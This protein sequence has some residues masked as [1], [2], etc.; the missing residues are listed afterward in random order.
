MPGSDPL[1]LSFR[2]APGGVD[3]A[4]RVAEIAAFPD[5]V[6]T[7]HREGRVVRLE[8]GEAL[9][10]IPEIDPGEGGSL[11]FRVGR[12]AEGRDV[13]TRLRLVETTGDEATLDGLSVP[14]RRVEAWIERCME[15]PAG[16]RLP[17]AWFAGRDLRILG[18]SANEDL[19]GRDGD[20]LVAGG[21]GHDTLRLSGGQDA[22][23]GG[24][25][26]D[27]LVTAGAGAGQRE[28]VSVNL[29]VGFLNIGAR[30]TSLAGLERI[31][32][33]AGDDAMR[34][35]AAAETMLGGRGRDLLIG[36]DGD[37]LLFGGIGADRLT[38]GAGDDALIAGGGRD[39]LRGGAGDDQLWSD[40]SRHAVMDG[41]ADD[42][43]L[44]GGDGRDR[45]RGG[46]GDDVMM[47]GGGDDRGQGGT[48]DDLL[49]GGA[50]DD[51]LRGGEGAD[52]I[53]AGAGDD[54]LLGEAGDDT[55]SGAQGVDSLDG[56]DGADLLA[57]GDGGD[58]LVGGAGDDSLFGGD[59]DDRLH[60]GEGADD[61]VGG[62]GDDR[63][64]GG[65]GDDVLTGDG[66][67]YMPAAPEVDMP[68]RPSEAWTYVTEGGVGDWGGG[69]VIY[70][71][72]GWPTF[73][74]EGGADLF[75]LDGAGTDTVTDFEQ[76][77]DRIELAPG[78]GF[79]D[80]RFEAAG[81]DLRLVIDAT[82]AA[83]GVL[84]GQG[85]ATLTADDFV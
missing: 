23:G 16:A 84:L 51:R 19:S 2:K 8:V 25:G 34:G 33:A 4:A 21:G 9:I 64:A 1:R 43:G 5:E 79:A 60:G 32:G 42:D 22:L 11:I 70:G 26:L 39:L 36:R 71:G 10:S 77:V 45:A 35:S 41:G 58:D 81:D 24:A 15:D 59:G 82:D 65:A 66:D 38:G 30:Q 50:G 78:L 12:D 69:L 7:V 37:D 20:D 3:F 72:G 17:A 67:A 14:L 75:V 63:L 73:V 76:G 80:L 49:F 56:G 46:A 27:R 6:L 61:L 44:W 13:V 54:L 57:G 83:I 18:G 74:A 55:L 85:G 31:E 62:L 47:L 29:A 48:G 52:W 28:G 68:E 53:S 40:H